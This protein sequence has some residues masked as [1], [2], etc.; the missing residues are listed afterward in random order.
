MCYKGWEDNYVVLRVPFR[1]NGSGMHLNQY[2]V[3]LFVKFRELDQR[4]DFGL[5]AS[6]GWDQFSKPKENES[7]ESALA[8]VTDTGGLGASAPGVGGL[9]EELTRYLASFS[10]R[11]DARE[12]DIDISRR[13]GI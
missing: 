4:E 13:T 7:V 8:F 9:K 3:S 10:G 1:K 6:Q 11:G 2:S 5:L 12:R